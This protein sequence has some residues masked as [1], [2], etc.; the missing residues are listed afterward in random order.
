MNLDAV[1]GDNSEAIIE[2]SPICA[3]E[4][5]SKSLER[6]NGLPLLTNY[7]AQ[8]ESAT[9]GGGGISTPPSPRQVSHLGVVATTSEETPPDTKNP[10]N[11]NVLQFAMRLAWTVYC[12][13]KK[14]KPGQPKKEGQALP[15]LRDDSPLSAAEKSLDDS[16][17]VKQPPQANQDGD[18][19][20]ASDKACGELLGQASPAEEERGVAEKH[21]KNNHDDDDGYSNYAFQ[22]DR[23]QQPNKEPSKSENKLETKPNIEETSEEQQQDVQEQISFAQSLGDYSQDSY[24]RERD[25][26]F[27]FDDD[28]QADENIFGDQQEAFDSNDGLLADSIPEHPSNPQPDVPR[29]HSADSPKETEPSQKSAHVS[30]HESVQESCFAN[31][32]ENLECN[33]E[34]LKLKKRKSKDKSRKEK[35]KRR[36]KNK[37]RPESQSNETA[38][39]SKG[40]QKPPPKNPDESSDAKNQNVLRPWKARDVDLQK[41]RETL[42]QARRNVPQATKKPLLVPS[43]LISSSRPRQKRLRPSI[44]GIPTV[45][46]TGSRELQVRSSASTGTGPNLNNPVSSM[47]RRTIA[48][49]PQQDA[50]PFHSLPYQAVQQPENPN[51]LRQQQ[52]GRQ[53]LPEKGTLVAPGT[54]NCVHMPPRQHFTGQTSFTD[55]ARLRANLPVQPETSSCGR[56]SVPFTHQTGSAGSSIQ[57]GQAQTS[58]R[59]HVQTDDFRQQYLSDQNDFSGQPQTLC[60]TNSAHSTRMLDNAQP[61]SHWQ[62][63]APSGRDSHQDRPFCG[64]PNGQPNMSQQRLINEFWE[65]DQAENANKDSKPVRVYCAEHF[66]ETWP[67][68]AGKL[69]TWDQRE[70]DGGTGPSRAIDLVD[71]AVIDQCSVDIELGSQSAILLCPFSSLSD[72]TTCKEKLFD[73]A[74]LCAIG[75]YRDLFIILV[76]DASPPANQVISVELQLQAATIRQNSTPLTAT[77][78][79]TAHA[80]S[81]TESIVEIILASQASPNAENCIQDEPLNDLISQRTQFLLDLIPTMTTRGAIQA[82]NSANEVSGTRTKGFA[83]LFVCERARQQISLRATSNPSK[84]PDVP[85]ASMVQLSQ[86][87]RAHMGKPA[88]PRG[89]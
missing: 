26:L 37:K 44:S 67:V 52:S 39:D 59:H 21:K 34:D 45:A 83:D 17:S 22:N 64:E 82:M 58:G 48:K 77:H 9:R 2:Q 86:A 16:L 79:K 18:D 74:S 85:S 53:N 28:D 60:V 66:V 73:I 89:R 7:P 19:D 57:T 84:A 1:W 29:H 56:E 36:K 30:F 80:S 50:V 62:E 35:K 70:I 4:I 23:T 42:A 27:G 25:Q 47:P 75:R 24:W 63:L 11:H 43:G 76:L 88:L 41:I 20:A 51:R 33:G 8:E 3:K 10:S 14:N 12:S 68:V 40:V 38:S 46:R 6:L 49:Q 78:I 87:S 55:N 32:S 72:R 15:T 13:Q 71:Y 69:S 54:I 65:I 31:P 81:V 61:H 5:F